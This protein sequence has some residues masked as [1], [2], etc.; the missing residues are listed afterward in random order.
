[1]LSPDK[2]LPCEDI[3]KL[4]PFYEEYKA[5]WNMASDTTNSTPSSNASTSS[6][7]SIDSTSENDQS[8]RTPELPSAPLVGEVQ[9]C[10]DVSAAERFHM[11]IHDGH[12]CKPT[13]NTAH[14]CIA[15]QAAI[16]DYDNPH[17]QLAPLKTSNKLCER[18]LPEL[19]LVDNPRV[20]VRDSHKKL[21]GV[22]GLLG[23]TANLKDLPIE[24]HKTKVLKD[25]RKKMKQHVDGF[26]DAAKTYRY[27]IHQLQ[28]FGHES[29][30]VSPQ[31]IVP[32]SLNPPLQA[33]L[34]SELEVM[35]CVSANAFLVQQNREGRLSERTVKKVGIFWVSKNRPQVTEFQYDQA[36][37][38]RLISQNIRTLGFHGPSST[39]PV[40][41]HSNL[42]NWK[43]IVKEMSVRTF[44]APD[45]VVRKHLHDAHKLLGMLGAPDATLMVLQKL[46]ERTVSLMKQHLQRSGHGERDDSTVSSRG[47]GPT[48]GR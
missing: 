13:Y 21:F 41:L 37:Q 3:E 40:L 22:D 1:M 4:N 39:N 27:R 10:V 19:Y 15:S 43:A 17:E 9:P 16:L 35:I 46:Q 24:M 38:L 47:N 44:C 48:Q 11:A 42:H 25:L 45:S 34:Y 12:Q 32:I 36:T 20:R 6:S 18:N 33:M 8:P 5:F 7:R 23:C 28:T 30:K 26:T 29:L 14:E 2:R 31:T